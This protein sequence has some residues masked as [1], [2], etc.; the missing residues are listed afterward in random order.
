MIIYIGEKQFFIINVEKTKFYFT[1]EGMETEGGILF[2][3]YNIH[4]MVILKEL[5]HLINQPNIEKI[6]LIFFNCN[7]QFSAI[8]TF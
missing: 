6:K 7:F 3:K 8:D 1:D 2:I 4:I 5:C